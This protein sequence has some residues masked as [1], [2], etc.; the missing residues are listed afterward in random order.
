M[1]VGMGSGDSVATGDSVAKKQHFPN[2]V[3]WIGRRLA[4]GPDGLEAVRQHVMELYYE[5]LQIYFR[6]HSERWK[7]DP[8]EI[9]NG[10]FA[11]RM[12]RP[13]FFEKWYASGLPLHRWLI[14]ALL[15]FVREEWGR[16]KRFR[17]L[18][19]IADDNTVPG[20]DEAPAEAIDRLRMQS[21]ARVVLE[22]AEASCRDEGLGMHW[23][24]FWR[25]V[26]DGMQY[27]EFVEEEFGVTQ[28]RAAVM[29]RVP[30][31]RIG[32]A[33]RE[34]LERDGVDDFRMAEEIRSLQEILHER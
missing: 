4:E 14:G 21:I 13:D 34:V 16:E 31:K 28:E 18:G 24:I 5:P 17:R 7:G 23:D 1:R 22:K 26:I 12:A 32:R 6:G 33:L 15:F 20:D 11:D 25:H 30:K 9:V 19:H 27:P 2:T 10:F 8:T 3:T 29:V